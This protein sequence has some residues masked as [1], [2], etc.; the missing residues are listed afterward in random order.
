[1]DAQAI[2][3]VLVSGLL[4]GLM[5]ALIAAGLSLIFGL[6]DV[7]NF[8][9]GEFLM[10]GMYITFGLF[11]GMHLDPVLAVP[12]VGAALFMA[13]VL[14]YLLLVRYAMRAKANVG[15]VQIFSTF[16]LGTLMQGLAQYFL[17]PDYRQVSNSWLANKT[18]ELGGV[19][20]PLPQIAGAMVSLLAFGGLYLLMSRT[21]FGRAL[22]ATREDQGAVALVGI[23]R[24]RVFALGWGLGLALVGVAGAMLANFYYIHPQV[25]GAFSGIAYVVVALGGFGSVFGAL[26]G[27]VVVGLVE[28]TTTLVL[29]AS[30]KTVGV[31]VLYLLVVVLRPSGLFGKL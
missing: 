31:Y 15:M 14:V 27:G 13:G 23:D 29:P 16:G 26:V 22:E 18:I 7:V 24:N 8:A 4:I 20:L 9:H 30:M 2:A 10:M 5:Y 11:V 25:G 17:T 12:I 21:D 28:A 19:F 6:M 3:Q 1:M